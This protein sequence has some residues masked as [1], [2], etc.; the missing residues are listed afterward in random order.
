MHDSIIRTL[1]MFSLVIGKLKAVVGSRYA[2]YL[3]VNCFALLI[4]NLNQMVLTTGDSNDGDG[5]GIRRW[6]KEIN[7]PSIRSLVVDKER[8]GQ[9]TC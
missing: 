5:T 7:A 8:I 3:S 4:V 9:A 6:V 2:V 1:L